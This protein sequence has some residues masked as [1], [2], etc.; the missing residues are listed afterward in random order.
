MC[1]SEADAVI[2]EEPSKQTIETVVGEQPQYV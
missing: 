1:Q 2:D